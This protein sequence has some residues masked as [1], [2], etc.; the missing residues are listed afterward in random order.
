MGE[1]E[2]ADGVGVVGNAKCGD[3]MR[4]FLD[5]DEETRRERLSIRY[6][7]GNEDDS[8]ERR[9]K[10]DSKDFKE[11]DDINWEINPMGYVRLCNKNEV[12]DFLKKL[13]S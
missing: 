6:T 7:G 5:I 13:L 9:L 1:I 8:L 2:N 10:A 11:L 4:I 12:D 3:I